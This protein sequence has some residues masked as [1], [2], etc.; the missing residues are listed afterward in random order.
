MITASRI[1]TLHLIQGKVDY[2]LFTALHT[3]KDWI[4][5]ENMAA[6]IFRNYV[7]HDNACLFLLLDFRE[8]HSFS[9]S[10]YST[11]GSCALFIKYLL[12]DRP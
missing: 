2:C 12:D 7:M 8:E 11:K 1:R 9:G 6:F 10:S 5:L 4:R 3:L